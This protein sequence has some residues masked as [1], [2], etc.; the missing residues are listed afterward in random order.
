MSHGDD[1][2]QE[3][4]PEEEEEVSWVHDILIGNAGG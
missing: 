3:G 4:C 1:C 2:V